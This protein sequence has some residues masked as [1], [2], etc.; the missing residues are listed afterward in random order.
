MAK[1]LVIVLC[2]GPHDVAFLVRILKCEG[3]ES[4]EK[5]KIG[6]FPS[7]LNDLL[8]QEAQKADVERLNLQEI[9]K[10]LLPF[11]TLKR[12]ENYLFFY[13]LGGDGKKAERQK[14][15]ARFFNGLCEQIEASALPPNP[16][17]KTAD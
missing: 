10:V 9:S 11:K 5:T 17:T 13:A 12:D 16:E 15:I 1:Q 7:P 8:K 14:M 6:D 4:N 3:F 2:E